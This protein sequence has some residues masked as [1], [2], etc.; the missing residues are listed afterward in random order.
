MRK[1]CIVAAMVCLFAVGLVHAG[2]WKPTKTV[3]WTLTVSPGGG[4]DIFT[5]TIIDIATSKK[6]SDANFI[7]NYQ[8]DGNGEVARLALAKAGVESHR[9]LGYTSGDLIAQM[10]IGSLTPD[11]F[12]VLTVLVSDKHILLVNKE[13][14]YKSVQAVVD[15]IKAGE[16]VAMGGA[17]GDDELLYNRL[18]K[19]FGFAEDEVPYIAYGSNADSL[20]ALLGNHIDVCVSKLAACKQYLISG[21]LESIAALANERFTA[22]PFDTAQ[23]LSELGYEN[24][25]YPIWRAIMASP[26]MPKAAIEY[27]INMLKDVSKTPEWEFYLEDKLS[28]SMNLFGEDAKQYV[29]DFAKGM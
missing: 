17:R 16:D 12:T 11:D 1:C 18:M 20:T 13:G 3:E 6:I 4:N 7:V 10:E 8:T 24:V 26:E 15:A 5:R 14:K 2:E 28:S 19:S 21:D 25:E 22:K 27:Y 9:I 29:K 23:T